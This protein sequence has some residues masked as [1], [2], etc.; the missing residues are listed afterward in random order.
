MSPTLTT[1]TVRL[2][3]LDAGAVHAAIAHYQATWRYRDAE[4]GVILPEG[5]SDTAGAV[6]AEI[7]RAWL[8]THS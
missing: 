4:G 2:D 6:L 7:C 3:E 5:E 8:E 1:L